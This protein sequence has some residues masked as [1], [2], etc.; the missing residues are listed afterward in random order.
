MRPRTIGTKEHPE[1]CRRPTRKSRIALRA[2]LILHSFQRIAEPFHQRLFLSR[3]HPPSSSFVV[4]PLSS[5]L[6]A[7]ARFACVR[8]CS[9]VRL[10]RA[11]VRVRARASPRVA[12][13]AIVE[14]Q[15]V[16]VASRRVDVVDV[17]VDIDIDDIVDVVDV[18]DVALCA[19]TSHGA[20]SCAR[21][22]GRVARGVTEGVT[23]RPETDRRDRPTASPDV[24]ARARS[25]ADGRGRGRRRRR[26]RR[27][28]KRK[29][30]RRKRGKLRP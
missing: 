14:S 10:N 13:R 5:S 16:D 20:T 8:V 25:T 22:T 9:R 17:D 21:W 26:R 27:R 29:R 24:E 19:H 4:R 1:R 3:V 23:D 6:R 2:R 11:H 12:S 18:V 30:R 7:R 15:F 28:R